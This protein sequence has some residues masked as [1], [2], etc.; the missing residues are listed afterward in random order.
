MKTKRKIFIVFLIA[1]AVNILPFQ[2]AEAKTIELKNGKIIVG[3]IIKESDEAIV[4]SKLD[5]NFVYSISR[6]RIREIRESTPEEL[7]WQKAV[8]QKTYAAD[9]KAARETGEET[10]TKE[11]AREREEKLNQ[12]Y[13]ERY[14]EQVRLAQKARGKAVINFP[15]GQFGMVNVLLNRKIN[16]TLKVDTGASLVAITE[17]VANRLAI[18]EK[19]YEGTYEVTLADG[20]KTQAVIITLNSVE[21]GGL[22]AENIK[23]CII[24][25]ASAAA[26]EGLLGMSFLKHFRMNLDHNKNCLILEKQK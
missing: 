16:T 9:K 17:D 6:D 1:A 25:K 4:I 5:G 12:A 11:E 19:N 2:H 20:S 14:K 10:E 13:E 24:K 26:G 18:N 23:A 7:N 15:E 21:V 3:N 22:E 8:E